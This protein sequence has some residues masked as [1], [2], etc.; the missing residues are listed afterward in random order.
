[1]ND[2]VVNQNAHYSRVASWLKI[3]G[4]CVLIMVAVG[5][6]TRLT[7]SGLS[8]T[9]WKPVTGVLPPLSE[10]A[11][12]TEM[13]LYRQ[14]PE[15]KHVNKGF[16]LS[17]FKRIFYVEWFHRV[18]GRTIGFIFLIPLLYFS[19]KRYISGGQ[20]LRLAG[21]FA[22][23]GLQGLVGWYMVKS[24]LVED[25]HVSPYR[26]AFH[27]MLAMFIFGLLVC[28]FSKYKFARSIF[29][30]V[31]DENRALLRLV[32]IFIFLIAVQSTL[33][34]FVAGTKAGLIYNTFPLMGGQWVPGEIWFETPWYKNIAENPATAQFLH[35]LNAMIVL[36][37]GVYM[38]LVSRRKTQAVGKKLRR[39]FTELFGAL[40]IQVV[41]GIL[42]LLY[43]VPVSL[44]V[45]HQMMAFILVFKSLQIYYQLHCKC[46]ESR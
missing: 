13:D 24:G 10:G 45:F 17:E 33:G 6:Y 11:W 32:K 35:R 3:C 26:L 4:I 31:A 46:E 30:F 2:K 27:L 21:L 14:S 44:G 41:L 1:M 22:L 39:M 38:W 40:V 25:P 16:S 23:G 28:G 7:N 36:A 12:Q 19:F 37:F 18:V 34:A 20:S 42:T 29:S 15:Y 8:M 9:T 5:G 43:L